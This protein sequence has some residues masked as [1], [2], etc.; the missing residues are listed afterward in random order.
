M[1]SQKCTKPKLFQEARF[2]HHHFYLPE[3][4]IEFQNGYGEHTTKASSMHLT[5]FQLGRDNFYHRNSTSRD[6]A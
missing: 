6:K 5:L 3:V 4:N 1:M 2:F